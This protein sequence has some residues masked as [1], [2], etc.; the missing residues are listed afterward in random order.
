MAIISFSRGSFSHGKEI[1]E[2]VAVKLGY[3]CISQEILLEASQFS[4]VSEDK[5]FHSL[6]DAPG[7]IDRISHARERFVDWFKAALLEH[8]A[9]DRVVYHGLAG[10]VLLGNV[11]R[12]LKV[13]VIAGV[14]E[15]VKLVQRRLNLSRKKALDR[16]AYEDRNRAEWYRTIYQKDMNDPFLYDM[17]LHIGRLTIDDACDIV[18]QTASGDSFQTTAQSRAAL[19]DLA[20]ANHIKVVLE[21]VCKADVTVKD[22]IVHIRVSGQRLKTDGVS[23]PKVKHQVQDQIRE[24][25]YD[26]ISAL[27]TDIPGVKDIDC[28]IERPYY[29]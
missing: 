8:L 29:V 28:A 21:G 13:R 3:E 19:V 12:I 14:E 27:V 25:L 7:L 26:Q 17:V 1:A 22:G 18:C 9:K 23:S 15:R 4:H 5:L 2:C 16:I 20:L 6:H 11:P 10:A 24:D